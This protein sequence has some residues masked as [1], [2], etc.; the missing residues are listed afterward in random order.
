MPRRNPADNGQVKPWRTHTRFPLILDALALSEQ[1]P[2]VRRLAAQF[3]GE[4]VE[5]RER[6][7][8]EPA[9]RSRRL[10]FASGGEVILHD[11]VVVAVVL[12]TAPTPAAAR[13]IALSDWVDGVGNDATLDDLKRVIGSSPHFAGFGTPY[14]TL[15]GGYASARFRNNRGW[16]DSGNLLSIT[17]TLDKPGLSCRPEDDDCPACSD[18]LVRT[19]SGAVDIEATTRAL[20][21]ALAADLL[22][23]DAAW[24]R[25]ADLQP[26]YA[27]GLMERAESQLTCAT[28]RRIICFTLF[29]DASA[30]FGYD[31]LNDARRHQ[32]EAI[33]PVE[34]WGSAARIAEERDAMHYVDHEPGAWF[35]V[36][37][38]GIL[39]LEGRYVV[40]SIADDSALIQLNESE[41]EAYEAGRH[42]FL[43]ELAMSIHDGAPHREESRFFER[44][45][46]RGEDARA[47]RK[48]VS[49]AIVNHT[50]LAQQRRP[51]P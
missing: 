11:E 9:Y 28:C 32:L 51:T 26:L 3:G 27:S 7:V 44:N 43:S 24:V 13:G 4:P 23:E 42:S 2:A 34:Q 18:L 30:T 29:R 46:Y 8:G 22:I 37:E 47:R 41:L 40:A 10:F 16:K 50:W 45:L 19:S 49:A 6:L 36:E 20:S 21:T 1:D 25:L 15:D 33:P 12:H 5:V 31:V 38:R 14:F 17:V 35:L 48:A 39:Y